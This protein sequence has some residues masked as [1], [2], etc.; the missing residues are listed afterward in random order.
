MRRRHMPFGAS[1]SAVP[2]ARQ[3]RGLAVLGVV[4]ALGACAPGAAPNVV[5]HSAVYPL[6][7]SCPPDASAGAEFQ[8]EVQS[9][10]LTVTAQ[11]MPAP[12]TTSGPLGGPLTISDVP[13]G[14]DRVVGLFGQAGSQ[15]LWRGV[16]PAVTVTPNE[17]TAVDVLMARLG[18]VTCSRG[19]DVEGRA[20]HTATV[21]DDGT[22]LVVGG[23]RDGTDA[24]AT[25]G[26][27]CHR[28]TAT[29]SASIF[30]PSTGAFHAVGSMQNARL[31][32][33]A[34]KL[35]DGRVIVAGG[36][37]S[38]LVHPI[39]TANPFPIEPVGPVSAIEVYDPKTQ[40]FSSAGDDP[41]GPRVFAAAAP[42]DDGAVII[43]GGIPAVRAPRNDLSN[44]LDST[45]VCNASL[46]CGNGPTMQ[47]QRAGHMA[48][49]IPGDG[50]FLWGGS[51]NLD[52]NGDGTPRFQVERIRQ[53]SELLNV[54]AM[55]N[56]R[57]PFFAASAQ[58]LSIR[59]LAVGGLV[60]DQDGTFRPA[61]ACEPSA[62]AT[63]CAGGDPS[64][65]DGAAVYV[66][67]ENSGEEG[68]IVT[69]K[70]PHDQPMHLT[71][72]RI[73]ASVAPLPG[74]SRAL[75]AGGYADL[76]LHPQR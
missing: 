13:A 40:S 10:K 69:G 9:L 51:V 3:G 37:S 14:A 62:P 22:V 11:D 38:A 46:S 72:P 74:G 2:R 63:T 27:G 52:T 45:T 34:A 35:A 32:H 30:D 66:Y 39:D 55:N 8:A 15:T 70:P 24:S 26:T 64:V 44:A 29:A 54:G 65:G 16:R 50:V 7:G 75:V 61:L 36:A 47:A 5:A 28:L 42:T 18:D 25:C 12:V 53:T 49:L 1:P 33:T 60:R 67:S 23:A 56:F 58:Y 73:F 41:N 68:G 71:G 6:S 21:L 20:F 59:V 17:D 48:F 57:N 4:A 31:F 76:R 43:T 19:G